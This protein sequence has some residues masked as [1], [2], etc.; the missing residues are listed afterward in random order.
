VADQTAVGR[1]EAFQF[2]AKST[3]TVE[4]LQFR[5]NATADTGV[6]GVSFGVFADS[7]GKPG[8]VLGRAT[9]AGQPGTSSWIKATGLSVAVVSGTRYWLVA[10]PLGESSHHLYYNVAAGISSGTGNVESTAGGLGVLTAESSWV[11]YNQGPVG[12]QAIGTLAGAPPSVTIEGAPASMTAGTSVQLKAH[13][14]NDSPTVTWKA[15]AGSITSGGLYTAPSEPPA[16]GTAVVSVTTAKGAQSQVSI[17][18]VPAGARGLLAGDATSTYAVA[19]QTAVGREEAFQFTAK[20]T[21]T[22]EE[23]QFRTNAT[24]D[25]GVS[26]VSFGVFADSGGKPGEVLGRATV[27]G[28]PGTS[29]W[30][31]ATGLSVAVVSGTRY[32]LVALPLGESSHHLYYNVA[33]GISSG[34]GNVESTAGGLGVLTAESS[35]VTYNQGPVGFQAIGTVSQPAAAP[36]TSL[37]AVSAAALTSV[38]AALPSERSSRSHASVMIE[39]APATVIAGTSVQLSALV[40]DGSSVTWRTTAGSITSDGLYTAPPRAPRGGAVISAIGRAA[41]D[42]RRI[43][44]APVP[45]ARPAPAAPLAEVSGGPPPSADPLTPR[46]SLVAGKL[47]MTTAVGEAGRARLSAYLA[48]KRLGSCVVQTPAHRDFTCRVRLAGASRHASIRV[49]ASVRVDGHL[50]TS[51]RPAAPIPAM[52]MTM[53]G[54]TGVRWRGNGQPPPTWQLTCSPGLRPLG[55]QLSARA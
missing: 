4:E 23:L 43:T 7:G 8:E 49:L 41:R 15:S 14:V 30:I 45:T 12:F 28:Q 54:A 53:L 48:G 55:A 3:G 38:P 9:V 20:S 5:T 34:T 32:W 35:W 16:G 33:A 13:V 46:A 11:T 24:A 50:F 29:S 37:G 1:E 6:S 52:T 18:V 36:A 21:G 2:T 22:V 19:D 26:G 10:L 47:I 44:I 39:G 31:K 40:S 25:T 27:A 51:E 17:E 42:E